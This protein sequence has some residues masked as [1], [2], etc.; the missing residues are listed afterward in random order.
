MIYPRSAYP[1]LLAALLLLA[2]TLGGCKTAGK[3]GCETPEATM[4]RIAKAVQDRNREDLAMCFDAYV[5]Y[6]PDTARSLADITLLSRDAKVAIIEGVKKYG[7]KDFSGNIGMGGLMLSSIGIPPSKT[8]VRN[9][10]IKVDGEKAICTC[11]ADPVQPELAAFYKAFFD[12]EVRDSVY[13]LVKIDGRW[14]F[15]VPGQYTAESPRKVYAATSAFLSD[16][17]KCIRNSKDITAFKAAIDAPNKKL[18]SEQRR[19]QEEYEKG[20]KMH[21]P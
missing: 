18:M 9:S 20:L 8:M 4:T 11:K 5:R 17:R 2:I 10:T 21:A 12:A 3:P 1:Y 13:S 19:W 16:L 14:Y 15:S 6:T 7:A